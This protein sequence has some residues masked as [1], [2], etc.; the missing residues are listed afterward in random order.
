MISPKLEKALNEQINAETYSAYLYFA[1]ASWLRSQNLDGCATWMRAQAMEELT[2]A[3][4]FFDFVEDRGGRVTLKAIE[5]P[6]KDWDSLLNV[7]EE[8]LVHE[9]KVTSLINNLVDL[10]RKE[11]DHAT[12]IFLQWFVTEQVE[13]EAT[14]DKIINQIKLMGNAPGGVFMLDKEL[15]A[16]TPASVLAQLQTQA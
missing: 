14:A 12:E 15:S 11:K 13:E 16:R 7:F 3:Q 5:A 8:V 9:Q 1:K 6:R 4:K 2:H 10:A